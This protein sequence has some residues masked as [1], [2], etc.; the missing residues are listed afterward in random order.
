MAQWQDVCSVDDLQPD[1]GVCALVDGQQVAIFYMPKDKI[2][3]AINNYDP[4]GGAN[5][6]SRG[7]IGD[8]NGQ[9]VVASPL[10][11]Q[12]FNLQT[13]VCLEDETV[14]IPAYAARMENG[15]VQIS[16]TEQPHEL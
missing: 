3:Y 13:G 2:V 8:I 1:S 12:H 9:P 14:I 15:S 5:V 10:Y 16:M 6:L 11:K 4:F 7:I